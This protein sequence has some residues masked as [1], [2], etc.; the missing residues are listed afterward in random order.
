MINLRYAV[1]PVD[2]ISTF[3]RDR[4]NEDISTFISGTVAEKKLV[5]KIDMYLMPTIWILYCF[6]Y[7][8]RTNIGNAKAAGMDADLELSSEQYSLAIVMFQVGYVLA[9][10]PSK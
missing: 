5:R 8:D 4:S 9:E 2:E 10:V 3:K 1:D 6:S 7:M